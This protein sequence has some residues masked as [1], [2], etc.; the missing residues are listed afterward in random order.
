M[1]RDGPQALLATRRVLARIQPQVTHQLAAVGEALDRPQRQGERQTHH[2]THARVRHQP[3]RGVPLLR[4]GGHGPV[5]LR[6]RAVELIEQLQQRLPP[7][8]RPG[9]Q[10]QA[11]Q[12]GTT[13]RRP[14]LAFPTHALAHRQG[15]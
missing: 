6:D 11:L 4:F 8:T 13:P 2:R 9:Q 7:L 15:V 10:R 1:L 3:D 5:Q 14:Q 12:F